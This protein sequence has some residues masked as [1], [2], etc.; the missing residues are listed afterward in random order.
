[1]R[2][3]HAAPAATAI[4]TRAT[5][6]TR[7]RRMRMT[8]RIPIPSRCAAAMEA[9]A[10]R[11]GTSADPRRPFRFSDMLVPLESVVGG[12]R[13]R[14]R[15]AGEG[16]DMIPQHGRL[17]VDPHLVTGTDVHGLAAAGGAGEVDDELVIVANEADPVHRPT[18]RRAARHR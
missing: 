12:R 11:A 9:S 7:R 13:D 6:Q 18:L 2:T 1:M 17:P 15:Y 10:A 4:V 16:S 3:N 14:C 5:V 8:S